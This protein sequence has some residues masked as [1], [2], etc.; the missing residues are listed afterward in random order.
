[1][2]RPSRV[3]ARRCAERGF[4]LLEV[5]VAMAVLAVAIVPLLGLHARN[6]DLLAEARDRTIAGALASEVLATARMEPALADGAT[7]GGFTAREDDADGE[8]RLYG[9]PDSERFAWS[10][11]VM[12][13][14]LP[15]LRQVRVL[16]TVAGDDLV[17]AEL[18][19]VVRQGAT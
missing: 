13:T 5:L 4:T 15:T 17:L 19:G 6:I 3:A 7:S 11:E 18:W 16:V 12:P 2:T 10:R 14:A 8:R 9:G 1:M